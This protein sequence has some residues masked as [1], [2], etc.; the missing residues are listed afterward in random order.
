MKS[1]RRSGRKSSGAG[2][3]LE[4]A[5]VGGVYGAARP[6]VASIASPVISMIPAGQYSDEIAIGGL[7]VVAGMF[8]PKFKKYTNK[9][10]T[11]ESSRI[12]EL[13]SGGVS[14]SSTGS[15]MVLLG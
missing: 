15:S 3:T 13:L 5:L 6:Y 12:G 1:Y 9:I 8:L 10:V 4:A 11:V 7:A 14:K 2:S